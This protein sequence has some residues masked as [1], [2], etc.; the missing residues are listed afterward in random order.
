VDHFGQSGDIP[1]LYRVHR[2]DV[3]AILEAAATACIEQR[4]R[5]I[6][7]TAPRGR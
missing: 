1:D 2:L 7:R 6:G 4:G 3:D 5:S